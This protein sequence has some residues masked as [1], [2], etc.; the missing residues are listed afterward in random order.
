MGEVT[1]SVAHPLDALLVEEVGAAVAAVRASGRMTDGALFA[2][3][4][5][6]EPTK[7]TLSRHRPGDPVERRIRLIILPGPE[8]SLVEAVVSVPGGEVLEWTERHEVRPALLFDDSYRAILALRADPDWQRAMILRGIT[9]F[10]KVQIDPWPTGNF[11]NPAEDGRRIV[12][13]LSYYREEPMDNGYA[14]PIEGVLATVDAAR[15]V[16]LEVLDFG[17]V[18]LPEDRGSYL[19]EQNE[20]LRSDLLPLDIVQPEG[21]SFSLDGNHLTWQRWSMRVAMEPLEGLV[22]RTVGYD[23]GDGGIRPV[24]HRASINEMVVPY[25]DPGPMH[26]WKNA[27]DVGEWGLGRMANS[28][29][30]GCDCLGEIAYLDAVFVSEHGTP[31]VVENAVCIHEEDYGIL[32]KHQDMLAG[33]TEVRRSR[34]LVVS[35]IA[36][37]GNY[38]YGFYW[39]FYLD[40]TIQLE[41]KLTGIM[42]TQALAPGDETAYGSLVAPGLAAP[43]HQHLFCARLDISVDGPNNEVYEVAFETEPL[44]ADNP[45]GNAFRQ[46]STRL[47]SELQA[48]RDVDPASGRHWRFVNPGRRNGLGRPVAYKLVPGA[49]PT[50]LAQADSSIGRRATFA[51]HNLWVTPFVPEERRAAGD[52]PNQHVGGDGLPAWTAADR[53][54]VDT[55]IVAW[56]TFGITH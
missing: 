25:G 29:S 28:L 40:G 53:S 6:E 31:Y 51:R 27:F 23:D 37:V 45:N 16:V 20:P 42:S 1:R 2:S 47:D 52:Y 19:P 44:G 4:T 7:A 5:L 54:L 41:V 38:E 56:H 18:P 15:G 32:W 43:F 36:T 8:S 22:L 21:P 50:L 17:A 39:Y 46:H 35:S 12:R 49:T 3:V 33:R 55:D 30:L 13:C 24:L 11:G 10:E 26:G 48:Q 14:R 34:R 9:D